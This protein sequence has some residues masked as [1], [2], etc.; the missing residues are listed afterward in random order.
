MVAT[1]AHLRKHAR[2]WVNLLVRGASLQW[3]RWLLLELHS[4]SKEHLA[5]PGTRMTERRP[6]RRSA[7]GKT[8]FGRSRRSAT[9]PAMPRSPGSVERLCAGN[10]RL[11]E[12]GPA[13]AYFDKRLTRLRRC[14]D[15]QELKPATRLRHSG[16][17]QPVVRGDAELGHP[18]RGYRTDG[19]RRRR[20]HPRR[21]LPNSRLYPHGLDR[22]PGRRRQPPS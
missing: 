22:G 16:R 14:F 5:S 17:R 13:R 9:G 19:G 18:R 3:A 7:T 12:R 1:K 11:H 8:G 2:G 15:G 21:H 4:W 10:R 6:G 20:H